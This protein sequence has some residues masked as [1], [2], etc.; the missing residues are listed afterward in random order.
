MAFPE[1]DEQTLF[2]TCGIP[3]FRAYWDILHPVLETNYPRCIEDF[4]S[5]VHKI[6]VIKG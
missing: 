6:L 3:L 2:M 1:F 5:L 4:A